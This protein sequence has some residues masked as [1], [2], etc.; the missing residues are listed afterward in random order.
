MSHELRTPLN[1]LLILSK[2]LAENSR[3][4]LSEKQV[5]QALTVHESGA[6]LLRMIN[7]ILDRLSYALPIPHIDAVEA[8][9]NASLFAELLSSLIT[10]F[11]LHVQDRNPS[12]AN[13]GESLRHVEAEP[14]T[15]TGSVS[16]YSVILCA[17]RLTL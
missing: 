10:N 15:S 1:S 2:L 11:L 13:F 3:G 6:E 8:D 17:S 16:I 9:V 7:D 4:N 12:D 5:E 14:A